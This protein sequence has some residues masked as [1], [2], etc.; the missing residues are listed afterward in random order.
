MSIDFSMENGDVRVDGSWL[1]SP[2]FLENYAEQLYLVGYG[3]HEPV[4]AGE[5][6]ER[7]RV[8]ADLT[9]TEKRTVIN[10]H[11]VQDAVNRAKA[12]RDRIDKE[13]AKIAT[14]AYAEEHLSFE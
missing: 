7:P 9:T 11:I 13:A 6:D 8:Y 5:E 3:N 1:A 10:Q 2:E 12:N 14:A 4:N